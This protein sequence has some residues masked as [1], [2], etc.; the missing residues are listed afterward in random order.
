[1][2][3]TEQPVVLVYDGDTHS[4]SDLKNPSAIKR[5]IEPDGRG[6]RSPTVGQ[7]D[8]RVRRMI[9]GPLLSPESQSDRKIR[10]DARLNGWSVS[11]T[12][13]SLGIRFRSRLSL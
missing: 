5:D 4:L 13:L 12:V 9:H 1:M 10:S 2:A 8:G 7:E 6:T 3:G 11:G